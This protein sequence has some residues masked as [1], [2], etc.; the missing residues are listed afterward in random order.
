MVQTQLFFI[1]KKRI[2]PRRFAMSLAGLALI[3]LLSAC[4][5]AVHIS[6]SNANGPQLYM[7]PIIY[8]TSQGA[9][10]AATNSPA[11]YSIDDTALTFAQDS[12]SFSGAQAGARL[13]YAGN[14]VTLARGLRELEL[15]Y[16]CGSAGNA[17]CTGS[18]TTPQAGSGWGVEL[19][20]QGG[21]LLQLTGQPF[22]PLV[23]AA[24]CPSMSSAEN[25]LFVTLPMPLLNSG[26][27]QYAW[28]PKVETAYGSADISAS[29]SAVTLSNI[30]QHLLPSAG[31]GSPVDAPSTSVAGACSKTVYGNTVAIPVNPTIT[32]GSTSTIT[33]QAMM[34]IGSSGLLVEDNGSYG[35][36]S[37][38]FYENSLGAGSGTIGF[39]K[40]TSAVNINSLIAAQYYGFFYS[41]NTNG[42]S[43]TWSSSLASFGF[44]SMPSACT[45][46]ASK[47]STMLY[48]GDFTGNDPSSSAVQSGGGYG[49]CDFAIDFGT[50]D[51]STNGLFSSVTVY[52][53][54]GFSANT[55]GKKY[56]FPAVA[57]A[58]QLNDKFAIFLIG[59][60]TV[61][62]PNLSWGIYLLQSN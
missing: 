58:G 25:F 12:Y 48:G 18:A 10:Y 51:S 60:D 44:S 11:T 8:G 31:G 52:V 49:N 33:P 57:I 26:T 47:T 15:T 59:E 16:A 22:V 28:N 37:A 14:I 9:S 3:S 39:P 36:S 24:T 7:S 46:I 27:T 2:I 6:T 4:S 40:P 42:N 43:A 53:G 50:Q 17:S 34:G 32:S 30:K 23:S 54:S 55:T 19:S 13:N 5:D 41:G 62:S 29:G 1:S 20:G 35:H 38:P 61:A 21:G 56:S 45:T